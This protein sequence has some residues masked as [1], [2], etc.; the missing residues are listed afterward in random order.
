M[1][2]CIGL[3]ATFI[4]HTLT[5]NYVLGIYAWITYFWIYTSSKYACKELTCIPIFSEA[6]GVPGTHADVITGDSNWARTDVEA[7]VNSA[8]HQA[9]R[10]KVASTCILAVVQNQTWTN[11]NRYNTFTAIGYT[12]WTIK[13]CHFVF[14]Y[15]SR[16]YWSISILF[17]LVETGMNTL[18]YAY[19]TAWWRHKCVT[20]H[21]SRH[22]SLP[23]RVIS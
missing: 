4:V 1:V 13:T 15:N 5:I 3:Q 10:Q 18:Q 2:I 19:L 23:H 17:V 12:P 7:K 22:K 6:Q 11:S 20:S 9:Q 16:V 21:V 8:V 14:D